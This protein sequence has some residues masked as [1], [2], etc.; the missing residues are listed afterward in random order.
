MG[1]ISAGQTKTVESK[2]GHLLHLSQACLAPNTD[3]GAGGTVL[4]EQNNQKFAIASLHEGKT[5]FCP[6]DLFVEADSAKF[7]VTGKATIHLT[8]YYEAEDVDDD[9]EEDGGAPQKVEPKK[10]DS[11]KA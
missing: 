10:K 8:G 6:L 4:V 1:S 7:S 9:M 3:K 11:P 2:A 5:E